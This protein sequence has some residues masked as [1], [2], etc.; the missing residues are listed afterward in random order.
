L[1]SRR[2]KVAAGAAWK[3]INETYDDAAAQAE[4]NAILNASAARTA[5]IGETR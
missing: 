3:A 5:A 2:A 1:S 4:L